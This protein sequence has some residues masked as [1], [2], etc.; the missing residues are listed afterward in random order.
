MKLSCAIFPPPPP[1]S[2]PS[3]LPR[4][5]KDILQD[6]PVPPVEPLPFLPAAGRAPSVPLKRKPEPESPKLKPPPP[7]S[8]QQ[9]AA[10]TPRSQPGRRR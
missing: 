2:A 1:V 6:V 9:P 3:L 5:V 4:A 10:D 7:A 8:S